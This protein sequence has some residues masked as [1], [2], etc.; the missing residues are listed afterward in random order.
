MKPRVLIPVAPGTN[1]DGDLAAAFELAGAEHT[2]EAGQ[3]ETVTVPVAEDQAY[4]FTI[5]GPGGFTKTFKGVLDCKTSS[6]GGSSSSPA[7]APTA[8]STGGQN[9]AETGSSSATPV[10]AGVA[11][12]LVVIG[13]GTVFFLR[14]RK[15]PTAS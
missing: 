9:L 14:K 3:S 4:D 13:G 7:P 10:I 2:V 5:T 11:I 1:R 15:A 12:G 8:E 6:S